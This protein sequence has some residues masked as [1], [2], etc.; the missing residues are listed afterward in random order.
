MHILTKKVKGVLFTTSFISASVFLDTQI[1]HCHSNIAGILFGGFLS[2]YYFCLVFS[3]I[4]K[5]I[6]PPFFFFY[7]LKCLIFFL[8]K[9]I[10]PW[11]SH[12]PQSMEAAVSWADDISSMSNGSIM[13]EKSH[14]TSFVISIHRSCALYSLGQPLILSTLHKGEGNSTSRILLPAVQTAMQSWIPFFF[15]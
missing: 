6:F 2:I 10:Y 9:N 1:K 12:H 4:C 8:N 5:F 15:L 7:Y 11:C 13:W 14:S 3:V